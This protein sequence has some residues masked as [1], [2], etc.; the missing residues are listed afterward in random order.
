MQNTSKMLDHNVLVRKA[1]GIETAGSLNS[2]HHGGYAYL[3][4]IHNALAVEQDCST[5]QGVLVH[6]GVPCDLPG[7]LEAV[8]RCGLPATRSPLPFGRS[9]KKPL[10]TL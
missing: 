4:H 1:E 5:K 6:K 7:Q 8:F 10:A 2:A 9:L 3:L